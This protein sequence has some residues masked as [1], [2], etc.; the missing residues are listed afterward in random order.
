MSA[1]LNFAREYIK[2]HKLCSVQNTIVPDNINNHFLSQILESGRKDG[3]TMKLIQCLLN[4]I[5]FTEQNTTMNKSKINSLK[6]D[7]NKWLENVQEFASGKFGTVYKAS[8][9]DKQIQVVIKSDKV[10]TSMILEYY[11]GIILNNLRDIVPNFVYTY[12]IFTCSPPIGTNQLCMSKTSA[13]T[14]VVLEYV[15]GKTIAE[16]IPTI[17]W[18][19]WLEV[20]VQLLLAL[21]VAQRK[22]QF[23]HFDLHTKNVI[24]SPSKGRYKPPILLNNDQYWFFIPNYIP[25]IIDYG[26]ATIHTN[27]RNTQGS[28]YNFMI[29]GYDMYTFLFSSLIGSLASKNDDL[30]RGIITLL[31]EFDRQ[32]EVMDWILT[33]EDISTDVFYE[34]LK[35]I[36]LRATAMNQTPLTMFKSI[37]K[38]HNI[39]LD[40]V[41]ISPREKFN[42]FPERIDYLQEYNDITGKHENKITDLLGSCIPDVKSSYI[43]SRYLLSLMYMHDKFNIEKHF[44]SLGSSVNDNL[45][46]KLIQADID[47]LSEFFSIQ[48]P[49]TQEALDEAIDELLAISIFNTKMERKQNVVKKFLPLIQYHFSVTQ[50][51]NMYY[52]ILQCKIE[53]KYEDWIGKFLKSNI[54]KFYIDNLDKVNRSIRWHYALIGSLAVN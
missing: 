17:T 39:I 9:F 22:Y 32:K 27:G 38:Q 25:I 40:F 13:K 19:Q 14:L 42:I 36:I 23:T 12:N 33:P 21:E 8:L 46:E 4:S 52:T 20:F 53:K 6:P 48:L 5:L 28:Q 41:K 1:N 18:K 7:I 47:I 2:K 49:K 15:D 29:P 34:R 45:S 43:L 26:F 24:L 35:N 44:V 30:T 10:D 37:Y 54:L 31:S 50:Y 16:A 11:F 51:L 3:P